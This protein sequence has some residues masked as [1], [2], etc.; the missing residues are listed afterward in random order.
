MDLLGCWMTLAG[1]IWQLRCTPDCLVK[2]FFKKGSLSIFLCGISTNILLAF[3][4]KEEESCQLRPLQLIIY[5]PK[6]AAAFFWLTVLWFVS[7][8][9]EHV[10]VHVS[11]HTCTAMRC[12][13]ASSS[14]AVN[15]DFLRQGV[16]LNVSRTDW[17]DKVASKPKAPPVFMPSELELWVQPLEHSLYPLW[18]QRP[19]GTS[20]ACSIMASISV[21]K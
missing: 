19:V 13:M 1:D 17:H 18:L 21:N 10:W 2:G 7:V 6:A 11:V 15:P 4:L 8:V 16:W 20:F 14:F 9:S 12:R 3:N 5:P